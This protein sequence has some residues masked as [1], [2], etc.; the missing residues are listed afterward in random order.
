MPIIDLNK[1]IGVWKDEIKHWNF[2]ERMEL[3]RLLI[4]SFERD[5]EDM[6]KLRR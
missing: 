5:Y 1:V 6:R 3:Q 4:A 2:N